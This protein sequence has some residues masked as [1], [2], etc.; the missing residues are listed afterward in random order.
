MLLLILFGYDD[1]DCDK[2]DH[3]YKFHIPPLNRERE[4]II[5]SLFSLFWMLE[6]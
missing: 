6:D 2:E 3:I 4:R 5:I 1:P